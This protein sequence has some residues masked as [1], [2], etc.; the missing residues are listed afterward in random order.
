MTAQLQHKYQL[1]VTYN[2]KTYHLL[3]NLMLLNNIFFLPVIC[4][5]VSYMYVCHLCTNIYS[6]IVKDSESEVLFN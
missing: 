3:C 2:N 5:R 6:G 1:F 4:A